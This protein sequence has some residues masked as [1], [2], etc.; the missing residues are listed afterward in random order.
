MKKMYQILQNV[1]Q[2][3]SNQH[4]RKI[5]KRIM[6]HCRVR[7][8]MTFQLCHHRNQFILKI[9]EKSVFLQ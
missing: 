8:M 1:S 5:S 6:W 9:L 2:N 7:L 3:A 4:I